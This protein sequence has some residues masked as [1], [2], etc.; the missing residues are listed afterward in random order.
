MLQRDA[1]DK[2]VK[3]ADWA[4]LGS[5]KHSVAGVDIDARCLNQPIIQQKIQQ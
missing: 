4:E 2:S 3:F 1:L 5:G